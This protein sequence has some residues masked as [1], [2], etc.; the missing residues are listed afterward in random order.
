MVVDVAIPVTAQGHLRRLDMRRDLAKVADLVELCFYDTLDPEG[1]QYLK[2]MR[3]AAQNASFLGWAS[4]MI[5]EAAMPPSGYVWEED[6]RLVGNLSLIPNNF[7]G[8]RGYMIANVATHPEYRGRGIAR[9]LTITALDYAREHNSASAWL[10]VRDDNPGA[11]HI[12]VTS[13]FQERLRRT[14]WFSGPNQAL[15]SSPAGIK[16]GK[17]RTEHWMLQRNWLRRLYPPELEWHIPLDWH[18][19]RTDIWG[20][21]YR[22]FNFEYPLHWIVEHNAE[23]KGVLTWRH[24]GGFTDPLWLAI[25]EEMDEQAILA[26]FSKARKHIQQTHPLSLNY[27]AGLAVDVLRQAGFY[28]HQTLIWMEYKFSA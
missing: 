7:Q 23:L 10:Q 8:R 15:P 22:F 26:L 21:M 28:P 5:D 25:P 3:R 20:K 16:V 18:L 14:S 17:R 6:G 9:A 19:F 4:S 12:Y 13:G 11:I 2:E 1:K 24:T 27:P